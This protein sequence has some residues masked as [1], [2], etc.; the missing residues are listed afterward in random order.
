MATITGGGG[1]NSLV[2]DIDS[3]FNDIIYG[4]NGDDT[5]RGL[6]ADDILYGGGDP[7]LLDGGSGNDTLL[8]GAGSDTLDGGADFDFVSYQGVSSAVNVNLGTG[9]ATGGGG[10]DTILSIEGVIG[11]SGADTITGD[12]L[13]NVLRGDAGADTIYGAA[14]SD[15]LYGDTGQD[16]IYGGADGDLAFGGNDADVIVG[17]DGS[18]TLFGDAGTD[19]LYG[20]AGDDALDGGTEADSLFGG[21]G[22]DTLYGGDGSDSLRGGDNDDLL[23]G[24]LGADSL[25]GDAG[26]DFLVGDDGNDN[27]NGG[28]GDD[29]LRGGLGA[30]VL[31]GSSGLDI[32]D[33]SDSNAAVLVNLSTGTFSGG[34]ATGDSGGGVDGIIGS[35]FN[36]TL[37]GF[38]GSSTSPLDTYT[39]VID[40]GAGNDSIS[41]LGSNDTLYGGAD[42]DTV[43]GDSGDD[44]VYGG[45]GRDSV[46]G[47]TGADTVFGGSENDTVDGGEGN[48]TVS[49]DAGN[50]LVLGGVGNDIL[51][52]GAGRDVLYGG[53]GRDDVFGGD[54]EDQVFVSYTGSANDIA[55]AETVDGGIGGLDDDTLTVDITGFGWGRIDIAYDPLNGENGVIT[56]FAANGTTVVGTLTFSDIENLV[57]VCFAAGTLIET[58]SGP[59]PVEDLRPGD[60]VRT[61]DHG[62]QPLRWVG[63]RRLSYVELLAQPEL[64]PIRIDAGAF[65]GE[66]PDQPLTVSPQHRLLVESAWAEMLFGEAEVLV[67]AKHVEGSPGIARLCPVQG[68][69]YVH[70][71]FDQHE[72][73]L[74]NGC[75]TESF[76]PAERTVGAMDAAARAEVLQLFPELAG[77][78]APFDSARRSLRAFEAK[79]LM[80]QA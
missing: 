38:D 9:T 13:G 49:G 26:N 19:T 16:R 35:V 55:G 48:D 23:Y 46:L 65:G 41:G 66:G 70:I 12:S 6:T 34:H 62:L 72:L 60:L 53:L 78:A 30:D 67:P 25:S 76:Q 64:Q 22:S 28:S 51:Y 59:I 29:T 3:N 1:N 21:A 80:A 5:L 71:L 56:F 18:D 39:N 79:V 77:A 14:G 73:V 47:G 61:R 63:R 57:I 33:Y 10:S 52:G 31:N 74:S 50:D 44:L 58:G 36:D 54:D 40:G 24:G 69:T 4:G 2:G 32:V 37:I 75:W 11:G 17:D 20:D 43:S 68:V 7:D 45:S 15:T 27:L 42:D 8:G